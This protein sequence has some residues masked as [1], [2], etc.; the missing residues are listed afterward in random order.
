MRFHG[1]TSTIHFYLKIS[2]LTWTS[3][4]NY[5]IPRGILFLVKCIK[6]ILKSTI[7]HLIWLYAIDSYLHVLKGRGMGV[8][9][10]PSVLRSS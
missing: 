8:G 2:L 6:A 10:W 3:L 5:L 1:S 7:I 4:S 9:V